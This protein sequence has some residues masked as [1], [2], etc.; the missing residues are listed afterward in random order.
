M[1]SFFS[2]YGSLVSLAQA[3]PVPTSLGFGDVNT[4]LTSQLTQD[5]EYWYGSN[6]D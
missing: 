4:G 3:T 1:P 5:Q 2:V 6:V